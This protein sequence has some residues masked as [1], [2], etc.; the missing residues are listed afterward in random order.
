MSA[1]NMQNQ[2]YF[3]A[4]IYF[5]YYYTTNCFMLKTL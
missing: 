2:K 3:K 4:L 1:V 5:V